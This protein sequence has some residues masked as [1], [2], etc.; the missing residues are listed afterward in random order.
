MTNF[1]V[2]NY[3]I[4]RPL[5]SGGMGQVFLAQNKNINQLVAIK[6]LHPQYANN[7]ALR[8][9]FKQEAMMLSSLDH[10][11]IVKFLN[12]VEDDRGVF[13]VMEYVDGYTLEDFILKKNGL[14][15]EKRAYPMMCE[16]L[17]AF[18]YAHQRGIVHRD[19]KP[20]N[21]FIN[22]E[23]HIKV[24]DFGIAQ[25]VSE[26]TSGKAEPIMGTPE[27]MSP[28]QVLGMKADSR[29]DIYSLGILFHQ[30]L[31]GRSPY[32]STTMSEL[33]IKRHV[34]NENLPRM[35]EYYPY[36]S[37]GLQK[38]V[39]KATDK[40]KEMRYANCAEMKK[41]IKKVIAPDPINRTVIFETIGIAVLV[42]VGAFFAWDY[43]H[44]CIN[45]YKDYVELDGVPKG[46]G[47]LSEREMHHRSCSYRIESSRYKVRRM[48]L[49]NS[50]GH[51]VSHTDTEYMN[52][53]YSDVTYYYT[54]NG[55][56]DYKKIYDTSGKLLFK[57]DYDDN[58]KTATFKYD[59]EYGTA[60]RIQSNT[61]ELYAD[62]SS[63]LV[64]RGRISR[65]LL[66]YDPKT[67]LLMGYRYAG[68]ENND[69]VGDKDNIYGQ[70]FEYDERGRVVTVKF[71]GQDGNVRANKIGLGIKKY[72]YDDDYNWAT[73]AY[74]SPDGSP[75]HDGNNCSLVE[76]SY[77]KW[78]NRVSEMYFTMDHKPALRED[79]GLYGIK[80]EYDENGNLVIRIS[81]DE[82]GK[83]MTNKQG[84]VILT[85][86]YDE[87]GYCNRTS[88]LDAEKNPVTA[89]YSDETAASVTHVNNE[90]GL[91]IEE[92]F[93]N[94]KG[95]LMDLTTGFAK[96]IIQYDSIGN[97]RKISYY[98]K[99][100]RPARMNGYYSSAEIFYDEFNREI[101]RYYYDEKG[102]PTV[103]E[104]GTTG[105]V[106]EY[107]AQ[108]NIAKVSNLGENG[109]DLTKCNDNYAVVCYKYDG[110]GNN[111][112]V[113]FFDEKEEACITNSGFHR[114]EMVYE[115]K[116]NFLK[117]ERYYSLSSL[118]R[119]DCYEYDGNGNQIKNYTKNPNGTLYAN[120]VVENNA[121]DKNNR[122]VKVWY[123]DLSGRM[124][125][126][127]N[128]QYAQTLYT[129]DRKGNIIEI[130]FLDKNNA[131]SV[132][133]DGVYKIIHKFDGQNRV[134]YEKNIDK[135][136]N[137][138]ALSYGSQEGALSYD[139]F[140]NVNVI[141]CLDGYGKKCMS[142]DG[143]HT[144]TYDYNDK[145]QL[146]S[147]E[148]KDLSG[149]L[150]DSKQSGFAK[151]L[152]DYDKKGNLISD[153][154]Y[155]SKNS[156][157]YDWEYK[158]N[159]R[160]QMTE[161]RILNASGKEDDTEY[162]FSK[163]LVSYEDDEVTPKRRTYYNTR[164]SVVGYQTY[165]K[166]TREWNS[167]TN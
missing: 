160:N 155:N 130:T 50:K 115:P 120:T 125:H 99:K 165:N 84:W 18:S 27:Y 65:Y 43:Y 1:E 140:G 73:V 49:V 145:N 96:Y 157:K 151:R 31:T 52:S 146:I 21:I 76:L 143:W 13:L 36:I 104:D 139:R 105:Y 97:Q 89:I 148:Y 79:S 30:M 113:E 129:Y 70:D 112:G 100:G 134:I 144:L 162:Y 95:E 56:I 141:T 77:D 126:Q 48:S 87:N 152:R 59:D 93:Y 142:K 61:T 118:I 58:L 28:E 15:V 7:I 32:D 106:A 35:K 161:V 163:L 110:V 81:V 75:S 45:Y 17:D 41:A 167:I 103:S 22:N 62:R 91:L 166:K 5:G 26:V 128:Q 64:E 67:H 74:Y 38:I 114:M 86:T 6:S 20:S 25:I 138:V 55:K 46:I 137:L 10:P 68:G 82:N 42:I 40:R 153:K 29:S 3:R 54:D 101:K 164:G 123:T 44:T 136:G 127:T 150:A 8:D 132:N 149:N 60:M 121:Y 63:A 107:D 47:K 23:G 34:I 85:Y 51:V 4:I 24:M 88:T 11:N 111:I 156:L 14:I 131:P 108:G 124:V 147:V 9:R 80:Y 109:K 92:S 12:Y 154:Y 116:T 66:N 72:T 2:L 135:S 53:R 90:R 94:E 102:N 19:I 98:D 119:T 69:R 83:P 39:D 33:E 117:E 37:D 159:K 78:G 133:A 158:Y 57:M 71:I 122:L 16:I